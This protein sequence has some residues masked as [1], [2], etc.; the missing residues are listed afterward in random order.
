MKV[1]F[2]TV[3]GEVVA[4]VTRRWLKLAETFVRADFTGIPPKWTSDTT[5]EAQYD[6]PD[7][8]YHGNNKLGRALEARYQARVRI[9]LE[10]SRRCE[11]CGEEAPLVDGECPDC[12]H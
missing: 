4:R 12:R 1:E 2:R 10:L 3:G 9:K 7:P 6:A 5:G 8:R 11:V